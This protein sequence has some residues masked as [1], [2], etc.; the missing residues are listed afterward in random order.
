MGDMP[1]AMD[2]LPCGGHMT[3]ARVVSL[4]SFFLSSRV[5][6]FT[7]LL[8]RLGRGQA[9]DTRAEIAERTSLNSPKTSRLSLSLHGIRQCRLPKGGK[10]GEGKRKCRRISI[11]FQGVIL[12]VNSP[13]QRTP[14]AQSPAQ[15]KH[16][17][18][19][20]GMP[21]SPGPVHYSILLGEA[22]TKVPRQLMVG[23]MRDRWCDC[24]FRTASTPRNAV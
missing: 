6:F 19:M 10:E 3:L 22:Q 9:K 16:D 8:I 12:F 14:T 24:C 23:C 7:V 20:R 18:S 4:L 1:A 2:C 21:G 5:F 13:C 15:T 17:V 11:R